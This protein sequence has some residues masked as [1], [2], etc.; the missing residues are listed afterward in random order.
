MAFL[1][2]ERKQAAIDARNE[3]EAKLEAMRGDEESE[4]GRSSDS[5]DSGNSEESTTSEDEEDEKSLK[6]REKMVKKGGSGILEIDEIETL[7]SFHPNE[8]K[9]P[10]LVP[11]MDL[12]KDFEEQQ[13]VEQKANFE[14]NSFDNRNR[15]QGVEALIPE[16]AKSGTEKKF[17]D[18]Q[19]KGIKVPT[20]GMRTGVRTVPK[21]S[22]PKVRKVVEESKTE[23]KFGSKFGSGIATKTELKTESKTESKFEPQIESAAKKPTFDQKSPYDQT[24]DSGLSS[25][26]QKTEDRRPSFGQSLISKPVQK[27]SFDQ[28]IA[29]SNPKSTLEQQKPTFNPAPVSSS[30]PPKPTKR[31]ESKSKI[32]KDEHKIS[33][34]TTEQEPRLPP[35]D[36]ENAK[37]VTSS[38]RRVS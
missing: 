35:K 14:K 9:I 4:S 15:V 28:K 11:K 7:R 33:F 21:T 1:G 36:K 32:P 31:T 23:V 18:S 27:P 24:T 22:P 37:S 8:V 10:T 20:F 17:G 25:Y 19:E 5:D 2:A 13:K 29:A 26:G 12:T 3:A 6:S 38:T 34:L 16:S 30:S